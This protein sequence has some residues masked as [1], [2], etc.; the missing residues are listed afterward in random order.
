MSTLT[1]TSEREREREREREP[2]TSALRASAQGE[3]SGQAERDGVLARYARL[4]ALP[5]TV[6]AL[7]FAVGAAALAFR[8][9][10]V[11]FTVGR[12]ALIVVAVAA[13]RTCAMAFN[14]L[15]DR[16]FDARNPRTRD[17][18]LPAG[19]VT[20]RGALVLTVAAALVF[21]AAAWALGPWP[22]LLAPV[23]LV[24]LL[25]YSLAKRFTWGTHFWLGVALG[26]APAGAWVAVT[27]SF[28]VAPLSLALAV[29]SWVA[30]FDLLYACQDVAFDRAAGLRSFPAHFGVASALRASSLLHVGTLALL[31]LFGVLLRL[32]PVYFVGTLAIA[33][34]LLWEHRLVRPDDL[35]RLDKAFFDL[36]GWVSLLFGACAVVEAIR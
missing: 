27:G 34:T 4:V 16:A 8:S 26:G 28:G 24:I 20:A 25:G 22:L 19:R 35:S 21:V 31:V 17:R 5:H 6:F 15:A 23:A 29:A 32:G 14:R 33:L 13:A 1:D 36:N 10:A 2:S 11:P 9:G 12:L 3:R 18:E 30:G 7:P